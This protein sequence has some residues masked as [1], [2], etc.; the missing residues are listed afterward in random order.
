MG[1]ALERTFVSLG[2][3]HAA[4]PTLEHERIDVLHHR[5]FGRGHA[6]TDRCRVARCGFGAQ[7]I[8]QDLH[9]GA[10]ALHA[11]GNRLVERAGYARQG[12]EEF[13]FHSDDVGGVVGAAVALVAAVA[14]L[15]DH[16][17][18]VA[19]LLVIGDRLAKAV[20]ALGKSNSS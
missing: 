12:S 6:I 16:H 17:Q 19:L 9:G 1:F 3:R 4:S 5:Q 11:G 10:L 8:G 15:A 2:P 14:D 20:K 13:D 7:Q 18:L